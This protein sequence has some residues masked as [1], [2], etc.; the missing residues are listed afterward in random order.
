MTGRPGEGWKIFA[1]GDE[2]D[3]VPLWKVLAQFRSD[4][5]D[6]GLGLNAAII[7]H[8]KP[9]PVRYYN[10]AFIISFTFG[11]LSVLLLIGLLVS[12]HSAAT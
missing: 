10:L 2:S 9:S 5:L 3:N 4:E 6:E 8:A 12:G 11:F 1:D 7:N